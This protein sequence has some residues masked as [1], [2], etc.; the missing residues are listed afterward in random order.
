MLKEQAIELGLELEGYEKE[1]VELKA[2][3]DKEEKKINE[4]SSKYK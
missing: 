2:N 1:L 3:F 4:R